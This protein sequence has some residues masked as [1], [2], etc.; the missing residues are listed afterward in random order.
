MKRRLAIARGL[1]LVV[2]GVL[3]TGALLNATV[4]AASAMGKV[5]YIKNNNVW[6]AN[7][8]GSGQVQ[9]T[10]DGATYAAPVFSPDHSKIAAERSA[11]GQPSRIYTFNV[12]GS[13]LNQLSTSYK[14]YS[15]KGFESNYVGSQ[16]RPRWNPAGTRVAF[17]TDEQKQP[18]GYP[19]SLFDAPV[20]GVGSSYHD[21]ANPE[22]S[23]DGKFLSFI[24]NEPISQDDFWMAKS[25]DF[26]HGA[27]TTVYKTQQQLGQMVWSPDSKKA[28]VEQVKSG[29]GA[30]ITII[31]MLQN[32]DGQQST[33]V[34]SSTYTYLAQP[35]W[36]N[37]GTRL[38]MAG[39][40]DTDVSDIL[41]YTL[42]TMA[43]STITT[44]AGTGS[45]YSFP[46]WSSDDKMILADFVTTKGT[47][48]SLA[49]VNVVSHNAMIITDAKQTPAANLDV[50]DWYGNF[51]TTDSPLVLGATTDTTT[52]NNQNSTTG[53]STNN[54]AQSQQQNNQAD[55]T[56][57][58]NSTAAQSGAVLGESTTL[59]KTGTYVHTQSVVFLSI[60][61]VLSCA[62]IGL[63]WSRRYVSTS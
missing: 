52:K 43:T 54:T 27:I 58:T 39:T 7:A 1:L 20:G 45:G 3:S 62:G 47:A 31:N 34:H 26:S 12:D 24:V 30:D 33:T 32:S 19:H 15:G 59:P 44:A 57:Q 25:Y 23:P 35:D 53:D 63:L 2:A 13:S 22:Y 38:V 36:S 51:P 29:N 41:L 42:S 6:V 55:Q 56:S 9:V 10:S 40:N 8:D 18:G 11:N 17:Y 21:G 14:D 49:V 61:I 4:R 50:K 5:T 46:Q 60:P 16:H 28:A 37:D 48:N